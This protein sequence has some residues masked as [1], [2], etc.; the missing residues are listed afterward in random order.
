MC[1]ST[2]VH[3]NQ[4]VSYIKMQKKK[5]KYQTLSFIF[6]LRSK[7]FHIKSI[8]IILHNTSYF[9]HNCPLKISLVLG[10]ALWNL[11]V[12]TL[13]PST[14]HITLS[15][16]INSY[17]QRNMHSCILAS[18]HTHA[19]ATLYQLTSDLLVIFPTHTTFNSIKNDEEK[20]KNKKLFF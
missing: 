15:L 3:Q 19:T 10:F 6:S 17:T 2:P 20:I 7:T 5:K 12:V 8:K 1:L 11:S 18:I 9:Q 16:P 13:Q 4:G 14:V